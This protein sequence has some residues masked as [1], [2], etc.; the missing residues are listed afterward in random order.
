MMQNKEELKKMRK[1]AY[2]KAKAKRDADPAYQALKEKQKLEIKARYQAFKAQQKGA[3]LLAKKQ[4]QA[5]KDG[6]LMEMITT[7]SKLETKLTLLKFDE[8][9]KI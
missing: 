2:Q 6:V 7:V 4:K 5:E 8:E 9:P 3:R 1:E